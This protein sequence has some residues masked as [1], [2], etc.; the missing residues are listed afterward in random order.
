MGNTDSIP[1]V[2]QVKSLVQV[3]DG[4]AEGARRTQENFS[5]IAPVVSQVRS[6]VHYIEVCIVLDHY[7]LQIKFS[8]LQDTN[9]YL[10]VPN[11][12]P[13]DPL[14]AFRCLQVHSGS[15]RCLQVPP[16]AFRCLQVPSGAFR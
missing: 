8:P 12:Y 4:D 14:G 13:N 1:V 7:Y 5:K 11:S 16:G 15:S 2:S 3:I 6:L 10:K 9:C